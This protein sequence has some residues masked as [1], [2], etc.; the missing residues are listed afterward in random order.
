[1]QLKDA[2]GRSVLPRSRK[3]RAVL[4][5]LA[6]GEPRPVLRTRLTGLLWSRRESEQARASLRQALHELNVALG[7]QAC[8]ILRADRNHLGLLHDRLWVDVRALAAA[9][10]SQPQSLDLFQR[11]LLEDLIGL[12]AAFDYWLE[13]ERQRLARHT[14]SVAEGVLAEQYETNATIVAAERLLFIDPIHEGAWQ[15]L[16]RAHMDQ[17]DRAAARLSFDRCT[18]TLADAGLAPSVVTEELVGS[19]LR[20]PFQAT[21]DLRLGEQIEG[22]RLAVLPPRA[23]EADHLE[24][25]SLGLAEEITAALSRFRWISCVD[26]TLSAGNGGL[27]KSVGHS[28]QRRDLDFVLDSTVQR[29][30]SRIRTIVRLLDIRAGG[31]VTWVHRFDRELDDVL[32]LQGEIAAETA[33][34][35][36]SELLL[37]EGERLVS[38]GQGA[39]TAYNLIMRAIPSLYRLDPS[40]FLAAG[41]IFAAAL[42]IEPGNAAAHAWWAYWHV[43]LVGQ[44]WGGDPAV[45]TQRAG[46]LAERAVMLDP[47]DARALTL[48]GHVRSFLCKRPEEARALHERAISLN[49]N[50]PLAWCFSGGDNSYMGRH[51][52]AIAQITEAQ[53]LSPHDPHAFYF[54]SVLM[55]PHLLR[56][57]FE[58]TVTLGRR[59][60]ALNPSFSGTYK[61]Y[62]SALGHLGHDGEAVKVLPRL[63][64]LEPGFSIRSALERSPMMR[65]EYL[66]LYAE[67]LRRAGLRE[68]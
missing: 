13:E 56:G 62:L 22:I 7:P 61:G 18:A 34:Q 1:M 12:D 35:I 44:G 57:D 42:A 51:E 11:T 66:A 41:E 14:R 68:G 16:I 60:I 32:I 45:A 53:R 29:S 48:V 55:L 21:R 15:A 43:L 24:A 47:A 27:A 17:G 2:S 33:A 64:A 30:G 28:G 49:P 20:V 19:M 10:V 39:P 25:L 6:L 37:R 40:A 38:R 65:P 59:S 63:L 52:E 58:T 50:L 26:S 67:G 36:D 31:T 46:E 54:D 4:A 23:L 5:V 8:R 3:T 9:T